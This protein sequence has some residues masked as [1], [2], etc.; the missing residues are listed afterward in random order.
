[1]Q[2]RRIQKSRKFLQLGATVFV[3]GAMTVALTSSPAWSAATAPDLGTAAAS[4]VVAGTTVTN[5]GA[6]TLSGNVDVSPGSAVTGFPPGTIGGTLHAGD[7]VAGTAE[8]DV[9]AAYLA[10]MNAIATGTANSDLGGQTFTPGVYAASSSMSLTGTVTLSGDANSV[11][12]FQ[13]VSGLTTAPGSSVVLTGGVQACNVFWQVG[14]SATLG[15][16]TSFVGNILALTSISLAT[17]ASLNGRA[18]ARNGGVTLQGN[19]ITSPTCLAVPPTTTTTSTTTTTVAPTTT[20]TVAP[21]TT[22]TRPTSTTTIPPIVAPP[23]TG[24]GPLAPGA[25]SSPWSLVGIAAMILGGG[26]LSFEG[27]RRIRIRRL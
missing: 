17:G 10:A 3:G 27:I 21:T 2:H 26:L 1:M 22:T 16:T 13:S 9:T 5:T 23:I 4:S 25:S 18:L 8:T 20:T 15:T 24:G 6:T 11:F 7:A 12:I 14:S 19:T